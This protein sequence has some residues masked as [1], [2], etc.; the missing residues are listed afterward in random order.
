MNLEK[1]SGLPL[2]LAGKMLCIDG[3]RLKPD[4]RTID[5]MK[6]VFLHKTKKSGASY[7]MY[8]RVCKKPDRTLFIK[9]NVRYDITVILPFTVGN[10]Y[11]K[12][13]GHYHA[14]HKKATYP[15]I[16]EVLR[17]SAHFIIQSKLRGKDVD[18]VAVIKA[19]AGDAVIV[20]HDYA[21]VIINTTKN[22]AVVSNLVSDKFKNDY[23]TFTKLH[24]AAYYETTRGF[25][26]NKN[27]AAV[28]KIRV[29]KAGRIKKNF[30][31]SNEPMYKIFTAS[32]EKFEFLNEPEKYQKKMM[33][34]IF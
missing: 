15:E 31:N 17:G 30:F 19:V 21:H 6:P 27:Y 5:D 20:P 26:K 29:L 23:T 10:E 32:P 12:T 34:A 16:Y 14:V 9:N 3:A 13:F 28:P 2:K 1:T 4:V 8:R 25:M 24:G 7:L 33:K 22:S 18:D 11:N